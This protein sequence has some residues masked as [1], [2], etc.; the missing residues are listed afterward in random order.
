MGDEHSVPRLHILTL[1]ERLVEEQRASS[2]RRPWLIV[3]EEEEEEDYADAATAAAVSPIPRTG[4]IRRLNENDVIFFRNLLTGAG[5]FEAC[6]FVGAVCESPRTSMAPGAAEGEGGGTSPNT[7]RTRVHRKLLRAS[8][9][10]PVFPSEVIEALKKTQSGISV[11][12]MYEPIFGAV[13]EAQRGG[14]SLADLL[15]GESAVDVY[16]SNPDVGK[17]ISDCG[18]EP[19]VVP[20]KECTWITPSS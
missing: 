15:G 3:E 8:I 2:F 5:E 16:W 1:P 12:A 6:Y 17:D 18:M 10:S 11:R 7:N 9:E 14:L 20:L 19:F 13:L 4:I